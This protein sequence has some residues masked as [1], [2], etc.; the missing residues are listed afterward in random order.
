MHY[1]LLALRHTEIPLRLIAVRHLYSPKI[2]TS[3]GG[4]A[5][6]CYQRMNDGE[7]HAFGYGLT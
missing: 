1:F 5:Q 7:N 6:D 2:P 4:Q 3:L